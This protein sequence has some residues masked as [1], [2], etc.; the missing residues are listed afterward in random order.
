M[1][2]Q[3]ENDKIDQL[4]QLI[5]GVVK[6][7]FGSFKE[8]GFHHPATKQIGVDCPVCSEIKAYPD[9]DEK[10]NLEI[11]Y[12]KGLYKCWSCYETHKTSGT[13]ANFIK[14]FGTAKQFKA[15]KLLKFEYTYVTEEGLFKTW[16]DVDVEIELPNDYTPLT[17]LDGHE[18]KMIH[19]IL[20]DER[21]LSLSFLSEMGV[22]YC[23]NGQFKDTR[24]SNM[25]IFPSYGRV[26]EI[27]YFIGRSLNENS[28]FKYKI[29]PKRIKNKSDIIFNEY[30]LN[31]EKS[32]FLVEGVLDHYSIPNS[33]PLLGKYISRSQ[34]E[35]IY[36]R[37]KSKIYIML[38]G[39]AEEEAKKIY[40]KFN[41]G[42]LLGKTYI[43]DLGAE[44]P[45][46]LFIKK[47]LSG[48]KK[49]I[50]HHSYQP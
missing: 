21:K 23:R 19:R 20:V 25:I 37:T 12:E 22:G 30:F 27:N 39:D 32:V 24:F 49:R 18:K 17:D 35:Q 7:Q 40:H 50:K 3:Y 16:D 14:A 48:I 47:G 6:N 29:I 45:S 11:N 31:F 15:Y 9:G 41:G 38:D 42:H 13:I 43:V 46:S 44:D 2:S 10:Y 1:G 5:D 8:I 4:L 26:G 36:K 34:I 33:I 28:S